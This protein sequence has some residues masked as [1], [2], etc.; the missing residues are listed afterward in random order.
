MPSIDRTG[1]GWRARWRA[2]DGGSRSKSFKRKV[3]AERFLTNV[4]S[5]KLTG[6]YLDPAAGRV[7]FG[8]IAGAGWHRRRS[9]RRPTRR[10]RAGSGCIFCR[11]SATSNSVTSVPRRY[12]RGSGDDRSAARRATCE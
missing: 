7:T 1:T 9:T 11:R 12:R 6:N 8:T 10:S 5:S 4:E 2:P 3:D